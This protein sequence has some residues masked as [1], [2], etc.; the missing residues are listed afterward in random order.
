M[1]GLYL[2]IPFCRRKCSYCDFYSEEVCEATI[3]NYPDLLKQH[4]AWATEHPVWA[5][6]QGWL[7]PVDTVYFGGGTPSLLAPEAIAGILQAVNQAL[8]L[9]KDVEI[10]LEANPGTVSQQSLAGYRSAGVN[11]LSLGLQTCNDNQLTLLGR[12][13]NRQE[14]LDA[15]KWARDVGFDNISL[16]L[17]FALPGQTT[18]DLEEDLHAYLE[19]AP[20]HLSCYGLTAEPETPLQQRVISGE[21]TLPDEEFY[22]DA[23]LLIHD[24][25]ATAG[26]EHYEIANYARE[27][28]TCRHNLGY[29]QRRS[30][31]GIGAG[32]H[33]FNDL[34]WGSRWEVPADLATYRQA[35]HNSQEPV[36]CLEKFDRE[37]ALHETI[38]LA[39]RTRQGITDTEL[40]QR[41][42]C[43]LEEAFPEAIA[44]ST[45]WLF[46][47]H[48]RWSL[49]PSGWLLFDRLILP[50]L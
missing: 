3:Q 8:G 30:C 38:Y 37:S 13:H 18:A 21:M 11:R 35:L 25:L 5:S 19:L 15:F 32:A 9:T 44:A 47:D 12:M 1:T 2:H 31:L 48:G 28:Y 24:H 40:Q 45:Q 22:A 26:Y 50:F 46:N 36:E 7:G 14:G 39:L 49:T 42:G 29:W 33:S 16:D 4:L 23:F 27:G 10:S 20:E 17:M 6:E 41:F 34:Q 43:T